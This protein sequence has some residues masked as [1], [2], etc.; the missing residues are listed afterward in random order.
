MDIRRLLTKMD[1][2]KTYK[3]SLFKKILA[4]A[5]KRIEHSADV[6]DQLTVFTVPSYMVGFPLFN[7][8]ECI[9]YLMDELQE[10]GFRVEC[11]NDMYLQISWA[12]LYSE[13]KASGGAQRETE[14][15]RRLKQEIRI[16]QTNRLILNNNG[17]TFSLLE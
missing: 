5:H 4:Q 2:K 14:E 10:N 8:Y 12:H 9:Q 11:Y 13:F 7:R 15:E 1:K 6:G 3:E 16:Q 17:Q